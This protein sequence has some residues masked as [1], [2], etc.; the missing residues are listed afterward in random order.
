VDTDELLRHLEADGRAFAAAVAAAPPDTPVPSC[1]D[2]DLARLRAHLVR[3]HAWVELTVRTRATGR[4]DR[5]S[6]EVPASTEETLDR[7]LATLRETPSDAPVWNWTIA[8]PHRAAFW[9]RRMAQETAVHRWD[10]EVAAG[11]GAVRPIG[12]LLAADGIDEF[13]DA[14]LPLAVSLVPEQALPGTLHLHATDGDGEWLVTYSGGQVGL[15]REHGKGD[16]AL[17]GTASDLL[18]WMW[19]RPVTEGAL[20]PFGDEAVLTYWREHVRF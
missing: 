5:R 6:M 20:E 16:A 8:Q 7:L 2:W 18:L 15:R 19:G 14:F 4:L 9:A 12:P 11:A 1:P 3:I 10:A 13:L 17:R